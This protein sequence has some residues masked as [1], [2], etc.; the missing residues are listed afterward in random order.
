MN[1]YDMLREEERLTLTLPIERRL[2]H[3]GCPL[4]LLAAVSIVGLCM[5]T[6]A[7]EAHSLNDGHAGDPARLFNP[8]ENQFGFLWLI[9]CLLVTVFLPVYVYRVRRSSVVLS[10]D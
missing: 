2:M 4:F 7:V 10:S 6:I 1:R 3:A 9:A 5:L 8:H